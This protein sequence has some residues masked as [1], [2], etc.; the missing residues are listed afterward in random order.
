MKY[1]T[2]GG[3]SRDRFALLL[4]LTKIS[5][6]PLQDALAD[7]LCAGLS[8]TAAAAMNGVQLSN[9]NR[10]LATLNQVAETVEQIKTL[11]WQHLKSVN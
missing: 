9:F 1:L 7:H 11:D 6:E 8:D 10:A 2:Q 5:S 4:S 3:E